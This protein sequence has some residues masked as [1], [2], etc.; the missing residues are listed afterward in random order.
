L[1]CYDFSKVIS[2]SCQTK[3]QQ[4]SIACQTDISED[5]NLGT[6]CDQDRH[7]DSD[8]D[9]DTSD[10]DQMEYEPDEA[11]FLASSQEDDD[12]EEDIEEVYVDLC[13]LK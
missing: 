5:P 8:E 3:C 11:D 6:G 9:N 12:E 2:T 4:I 10:M 7:E 13:L 1:V